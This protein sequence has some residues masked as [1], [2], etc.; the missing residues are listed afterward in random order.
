[1]ILHLPE[2]M[3][4]FEK[5]GVERQPLLPKTGQL[6]RLYCRLTE[7]N[8][9]PELLLESEGE[10]TLVPFSSRDKD[11]FQFEIGPFEHPQKLT[12]RFVSGAEE[13]EE[14][15]FEV[16][17]E[18]RYDSVTQVL[19]QENGVLLVL[20]TDLSLELSPDAVMTLRQGQ[21]A[22]KPSDRT[23]LSL[24]DSHVFHFGSG[25]LWS[26]N[27]LSSPVAEAKCYKV[28]RDR[29]GRIWQTS[30]EVNIKASHI[31]GTGERFDA[32]DQMGL[33]SNGRVVEKFTNQGAMSYIPIPFF[34][35]DEGLGWYREGSI[36][37]QMGFQKTVSLTQRAQGSLLSKDRLF[38]GT[39]SSMLSSFIS[40]TGK[41]V[42]PPEWA[43]GV[44]ISGNGWKDDEDVLEQLNMLK[45]HRYPASVMVLEQWSDEQT[46]YRWHETHFPRPQDTVKAI[47]DAGLHLILWQIPVI[48]HDDEFPHSEIHENDIREAIE[49][50]YVIKRQDGSPYRVNG[51]WFANSLLPDFTSEEARKWWFGKRKYLLDMGVEGF[52][53]D[54]GEFLFEE[55]A[56]LYNGMN[57]LQAHN[58]YPGQYIAAYHQFLKDN[59]VAGLT[60]SRAGYLGAQT[61][62]AHWAGD[63]MSTWEELQA[64]LRA[65]LSSGLSGLLF[66]G[67]D[68][69]GFAGPIPEAE[70]YLRATAL[71]CF[72][73]IMQWHSEPRG[74]Q[75]GGRKAENN[76]RSPWNLARRLGDKRVLEIGVYFAQLRESLRPYL[77]E[78]ATM[79][80]AEGRP[81]MA[82]LCLDYPGD[83]KVYAIDDQFMLG[84][85]LMV[86][87]IVQKGQ[88]RRTVYLPEGTWTDYFT[89]KAFKGGQTILCEATLDRIPVFNRLNG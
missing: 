6:V 52:K 11:M 62:P 33:G 64:Q 17:K 85:G 12:Y 82:H 27:R 89:G 9:A 65:G 14:F 46:F 78:Q 4:P 56:K 7:G 54:G 30:L 45:D 3:V 73:P 22:G 55:G 2:G 23:Q 76:D 77:L 87:P 68:I 1:M 50:Q 31:L 16:L 63:Q 21:P 70:L 81:L 5:D 19:E 39:P 60:F 88:T 37:T 75:Y 29:T 51:R 28:L 32:V 84:H 47:R 42:L 66:W 24:I 59:G 38:F 69:G 49:K 25:S 71:A 79:C 43:F 74:G 15:E 61:Q 20:D 83:K 35:T 48:K 44:W 26:L 40:L 18:T 67:F 72:S 86:A 13:S 10:E 34:M 53:T 41:P 8:T 58:L 57:G 36:A 80:V